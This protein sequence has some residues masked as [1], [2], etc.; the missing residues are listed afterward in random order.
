MQNYYLV[1]I[2]VIK[3]YCPTFTTHTVSNLVKNQNIG[4]LRKSSTF[5]NFSELF[6]LWP[7]KQVNEWLVVFR[8][9]L[10]LLSK[11]RNQ[12]SL[13]QEVPNKYLRGSLVMWKALSA[14]SSKWSVLASLETVITR[15]I[16]LLSELFPSYT[17]T[18]SKTYHST[19]FNW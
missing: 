15:N 1:K 4:P 6:S 3:V 17:F 18:I 13:K 5:C 10:V 12:C 9:Q 8:F 7:F 19:Y 16:L 2:L 14:V 11:A